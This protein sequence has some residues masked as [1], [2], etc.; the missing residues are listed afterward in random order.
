M[1]ILFIQDSAL[2]ES[3]ALTELSGF[4]KSLG[5]DCALL[6]EREEKDLWG[7]AEKFSP[8]IFLIPCSLFAHKWAIS[9]A[10]MIK[11][12]FDKPVIL[13]GTHPTFF[14]DILEKEECIDIICIGET[15]LPVSELLSRMEISS[16]ITTIKNLWVKIKGRVYKNEVESLVRDLGDLPLP[17]RELYYRYRFIRDLPMKRFSSGRGCCHSCAYCLEPLLREKYKYKVNYAR[18][19]S[20]DR[21]IEEILWIKDKFPLRSLHFSDDIFTFDKKWVIEFADKYRR[22]IGLPFTFNADADELDE[23]I[24]S[25]VKGANCSGIAIGIETGSERIR[26][27]I[28]DKGISNRDLIRIAGLIKKYKLKLITF[29]MLALPGESIEEAFETLRLNNKIK[30]DFIRL[31]IAFPM[32]MT[33]FT[34]YALKKGF[35]VNL[36]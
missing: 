24:I 30:T 19:K 9:I 5:H 32:P 31:T 14:P 11:S 6:L 17:D 29:N 27:F 16:D 20:V 13:S 25:A 12:R 26:N 15:E 21:V 4:L 2:N 1:K 28:M 22:Q 35:I 23:E 7:E 10:K 34:L 33:R 18:K 36:D 8:D 3:L